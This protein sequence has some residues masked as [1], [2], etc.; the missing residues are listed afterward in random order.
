[1]QVTADISGPPATRPQLFE[2]PVLGAAIAAVTA[3]TCPGRSF[4]PV[5]AHHAL[6]DELYR[7]VYPC[8]DSRTTPL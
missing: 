1:M 5:A 8:M 2:T 4:E 6:Q 3:M 7:E